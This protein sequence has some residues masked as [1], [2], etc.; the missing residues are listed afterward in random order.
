MVIIALIKIVILC[1][2]QICGPLCPFTLP[3]GFSIATPIKDWMPVGVFFLL[4]SLQQAKRDD[5]KMK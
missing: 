1:G 5:E 3:K 4:H 2:I